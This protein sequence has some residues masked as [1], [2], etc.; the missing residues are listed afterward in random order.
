MPPRAVKKNAVTPTPKK[1]AAKTPTKSPKTVPKAVNTPPPKPETE[2]VDNTKTAPSDTVEASKVEAKVVEPLQDLN[3][4][5]P[6]ST[7]EAIGDAKKEEAT[8]IRVATENDRKPS[9]EE[10]V[11]DAR[12][13]LGGKET[14]QRLDEV[15]EEGEGAV[16]SHADGSG[17]AGGDEAGAEVQGEEEAEQEGLE[18]DAEG[19][20]GVEGEEEHHEM[21]APVRERRKQ[22][23]F[24]VFVGGL[25]KDAVEEDLK[26]VFS[27]V[28]E[29]V[30]VRLARNSQ[31]QKNKGFAFIRF[32]TVEQAKKAVTDLKN[33][34]V[35]G[36]Q[37]GVTRSQ[38]NETLYVRN[39]CRTWTKG[40]L[41]SK[42]KDY[43]VENIEELT[44]MDDP[45]A[46]GMNRGF[47]FLEF[48]THLD[49]TNAFKRLQ[50][51][52]VF[53]GI[54]LCAKVA[55][56]KSGIEPDEE[57][58]AQVKSVFVDGLPASWDEE[59]V[60]E[61]FKKYGEIEKVQL[62]RNMPSAKRKD[63]GFVC[64][65]TREA[66][67]A[68]IEGVNN[69][70]LNEGDNKVTMK[71]TLR[72]PQQKGRSVKDGVRGGYQS[73]Y[74]GGRGGRV[75]WGHGPGAFE[76]RRLG[77]RG[78][79]SVGRGGRFGVRGG[80]RFLEEREYRRGFEDLPDRA[81][82]RRLPASAYARSSSRR[83][84]REQAEP[85]P[86]RQVRPSSR[87][88]TA[89]PRR[90][91]Y[92]DDYEYHG[93]G[94]SDSLPPSRSRIPS[95]RPSYP[96]ESYGHPMDQVPAYRNGPA[97]DYET[98]SGSKRAYSALDNE[99]PYTGPPARHTRSRLDYDVGVGASHYGVPMPGQDDQLGYTGGG[100]AS[101][102]GSLGGGRAGGV[103]PSNYAS[104]YLPSGTDIEGGSYSS[105][106][107]NRSLG[108]GYLPGSG[109]GTYY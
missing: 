96:E 79:V 107:S 38:D 84:Y 109:S 43:G 70:E 14:A 58:M 2:N 51:R 78:S 77:G 7:E 42:L 25:D 91:S 63:F 81:Y 23:E 108:G 44:L 66:A 57:V 5:D 90:S 32:A 48:N 35:R 89:P 62:A 68:C 52:D 104:D 24:E 16:E 28:G 50:K 21:P 29:V 19:G 98:L 93:S 94:Y 85:Y 40:A 64:F 20:E 47:A 46:E 106:Y 65:I 88:V 83:D 67:M 87:S 22:K 31:T 37:C 4:A 26:K 17:E 39:I 80:R 13:E 15:M 59:R 8:E 53:F 101:A 18:E 36:K 71:A 95:H 10:G 49:A 72:K 69:N 105:V 12:L 11:N 34:K 99:V 76:S 9:T 1:V 41:R 73:S 75:P 54:D 102:A 103:H 3:K 30:E 45:Q 27:E 55:F 60:Q 74:S 61:K 33:P 100:R 97:R 82:D 6:A 92:R 56:A 86:D